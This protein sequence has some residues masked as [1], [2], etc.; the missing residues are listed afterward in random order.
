MRVQCENATIA[1][2]GKF[3][4]AFTPGFRASDPR[5]PGAFIDPSFIV[6][7]SGDDPTVAVSIE[8]SMA[9]NRRMLLAT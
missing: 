8:D 2:A 7:P 9:D 5:L 1:N 3:G 4:V 6:L